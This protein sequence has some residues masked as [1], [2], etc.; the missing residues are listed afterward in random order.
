MIYG[1][2]ND[3]YKNKYPRLA[4]VSI[5]SINFLA[6]PLLIILAILRNKKF[7]QEEKNKDKSEELNDI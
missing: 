6:V 1:Y 4:M 2:I 5:M 3:I 7:D